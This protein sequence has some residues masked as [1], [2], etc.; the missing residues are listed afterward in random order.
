LQVHRHPNPGYPDIRFDPCVAAARLSLHSQDFTGYHEMIV[1]GF[2]LPG[3]RS[4][5]M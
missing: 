2:T 4:G 3:H 1:Q 5:C